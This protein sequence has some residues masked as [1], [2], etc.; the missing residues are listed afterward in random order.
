MACC[1]TLTG[2]IDI[3][4]ALN[5]GGIARLFFAPLCNITGMTEGSGATE[6]I[7]TAIDMSG[8]NVFY[9]IQ[10]LKNTAGITEESQFNN[11]L[12][13][14]F[15]KSTIVGTIPRREVAKRNKLMTLQNQKLVVIA[16]DQNDKYWLLGRVNGALIEQIGGGFGLKK[17]ELNG[18]TLSFTTEENKMSY[19]IDSS[20]ITNGS[21]VGS[22]FEASI[23]H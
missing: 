17:D 5:T 23:V 7:I 16:R 14:G 10:F 9:E 22:I 6:G 4:C 18:Y 15:Y 19:E 21:V 12:G 13:T 11:E 3:S 2:N 8:S 20:L 1:S